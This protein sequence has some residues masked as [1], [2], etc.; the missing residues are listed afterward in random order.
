MKARK[1]QSPELTNEMVDV[2]GIFCSHENCTNPRS[3]LVEGNPGIG[4]TTFCQKLAKHW[5]LGVIPANCSFPKVELVLLLK[6]RDIYGDLRKEIEDQLLPLDVTDQEKG[7]FWEFLQDIQEKLLI[8]L[9]GLDELKEHARHDV[10]NL[11]LRNIF[12]KCFL[13]V[14][15][16]QERGIHVRKNFDTLLEIKGFT[17]DDAFLYIQRHFRD[18]EKESLA[19]ALIEQISNNNYLRELLQNPLN[20]VLLCLVFED[21]EGTLPSTRTELY[22]S[23]I[24]CILKRYCTKQAVPFDDST[25][26]KQF[27][28]VLLALGELALD[29][30][31]E[32]ILYFSE[33]KLNSSTQQVPQMGL[34]PKRPVQRL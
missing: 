17:K 2:Y 13:V 10:D 12:P 7:H 16:R 30:L 11:L 6:C 28:D 34:F 15:A 31:K 29:G 23:I 9:D 3:V 14:S 1:M 32:D 22:W 26:I 20:T 27:E 4:K 5:A 25:L 19:T 18:K 21:C 24:F 33:T 8:I